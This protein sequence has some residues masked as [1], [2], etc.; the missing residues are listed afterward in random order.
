MI[1]INRNLFFLDRQIVREDCNIFV[2]FEQRGKTLTSIYQDFFNEAELTYKDFFNLC[3]EVWRESY[4][5]IV[6]DISQNKN[7]K[8]KLAVNWDLKVL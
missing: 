2:L 7:I 3:N 8:G 6:I 5:N 1:Y 4:N